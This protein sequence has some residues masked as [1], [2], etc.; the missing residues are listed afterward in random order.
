MIRKLKAWKELM[1]LGLNVSK[2]RTEIDIFF[3]GNILGVLR[4]EGWF[5]LLRE[6]KTIM[7]IASEYKYT[8]IEFLEYLLSILLEDGVIEQDDDHLFIDEEIQFAWQCPSCFDDA[9]Q[10]LWVD[11]ARA[12]PDRL[13]GKYI[14]F[15]GGLNLFN[16]DD[17]LSNK[18]YE[19]IRRAA[20]AFADALK[21]PIRF[22]DVGS[23]NGRGTAA[24]WSYYYEN[25]LFQ[26]GSPM[27]I[28]AID[29]DENLLRIAQEEFAQMV[30]EH[31]GHDMSIKDKVNEFPVEFHPGYAEN[32]P[33]DDET[34]DIVYASQV[35]HWTDPKSA[36]T[37]MLRVL[38]PG[39][40]LFGTQNFY[41]DANKYGEAHFKVVEG[42]YGFFYKDTM[43]EWVKEAGAARFETATPISVFKV[44]KGN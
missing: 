28:V 16:W 12:I 21:E 1:K 20:F 38:K 37:E 24:I 42:A 30:S 6:P 4:N 8:D 22:L 14:E 23:G 31:N 11:H 9:M 44:T 26:N 29:P 41:P 5:D 27:Q 19:Q 18:L 2:L 3:R 10:E 17:A 34:F 33:F 32:I 7:E 13:R 39:G 35:L 40:F 36:I 15:T 25:D 43:E